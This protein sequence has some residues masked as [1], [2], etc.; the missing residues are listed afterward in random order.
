MAHRNPKLSSVTLQAL[1]AAD[2]LSAQAVL[3]PTAAS[4]IVKAARCVVVH[5][6]AKHITYT[7]ITRE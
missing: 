7:K 4:E 2:P 1:A 3:P 5:H 6:A